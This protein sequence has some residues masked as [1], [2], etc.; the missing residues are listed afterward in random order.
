VDRLV[1][2]ARLQLSLIVT[3][4]T[5]GHLAVHLIAYSVCCFVLNKHPF[6]ISDDV[7]LV[8]LNRK[9]LY[10]IPHADLP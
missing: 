9:D 1:A 3:R 10:T 8:L 5:E 2:F 7:D 6:S 4:L